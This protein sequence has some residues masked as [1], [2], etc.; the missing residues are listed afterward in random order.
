MALYV[1]GATHDDLPVLC[2]LM[3]QLSGQEITL[4]QMK[5]RLQFVENSPFYSLYVCEEHTEVIGLLG[6]RI[7][8]NLEVVSR[9][10]EITAIV[11]DSTAYRKGVGRFLMDIAEQ[12]AIKE[13]CCGTWL[14]SGLGRKEQA[15]K[16][17][18]ELGY[19]VTGARFVKRFQ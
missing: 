1:L 15:H 5:D 11:V 18:N 8:E 7:R 19:E 6:F 3:E 16:F 2:K 17:Y 12:L 13:G 14:V 4:E 10:G 9:Y